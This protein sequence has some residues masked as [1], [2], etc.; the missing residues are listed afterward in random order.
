MEY[1]L[2]KEQTV[3]SIDGGKFDQ[4][5]VTKNPRYVKEIILGGEVDF[6]RVLPSPTSSD[7]DRPETMPEN[8]TWYVMTEMQGWNTKSW[9]IWL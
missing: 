8:S 5:S 2:S 6:G 4:F 1:G 7:Y 9:Y 3:R